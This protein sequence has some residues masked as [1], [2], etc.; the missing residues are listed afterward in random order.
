[1]DMKYS[2]NAEY[3]HN[4]KINKNNILNNKFIKPTILYFSRM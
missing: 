1:M 2:N 3:K 4:Y